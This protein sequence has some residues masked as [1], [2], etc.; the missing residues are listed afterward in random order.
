MQSKSKQCNP[1]ESDTHSIKCR[2]T[3]VYYMFTKSVINCNMK[4]RLATKAMDSWLSGGF[5]DKSDHEHTFNFWWIQNL[6]LY[7]CILIF[8]RH[9]FYEDNLKTVKVVYQQNKINLSNIPQL[10]ATYKHTYANKWTIPPATCKKRRREDT[11]QRECISR[12]TRFDPSRDILS[13]RENTC[14]QLIR[15][16]ARK[17][18]NVS[19]TGAVKNS[20]E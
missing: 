2:N 4:L 15:N 14:G 5:T 9:C 18:Y 17:A 8:V 6:Y 7:Y 3:E 13:N 19:S 11:R 1:E 20:Q 12:A 10:Q 16:A